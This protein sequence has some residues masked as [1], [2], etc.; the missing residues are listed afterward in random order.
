MS[1]NKN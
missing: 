1:R